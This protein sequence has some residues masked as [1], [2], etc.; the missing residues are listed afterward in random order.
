MRD[1]TF[2]WIGISNFEGK[3]LENELQGRF[4]CLPRQADI[5]FW[6][7]NSSHFCAEKP[8]IAFVEFVKGS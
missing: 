3:S 5:H 4:Y 7:S 6:H 8:Y 1:T 2:M